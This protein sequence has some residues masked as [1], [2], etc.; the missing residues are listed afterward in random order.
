MTG[1]LNPT[2]KEEI[3]IYINSYAGPQFLARFLVLNGQ[4]SSVKTLLGSTS[5][6]GPFAVVGDGSARRGTGSPPFC[7]KL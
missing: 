5:V 1:G 4:S 3:A 7:R 2:R 6:S